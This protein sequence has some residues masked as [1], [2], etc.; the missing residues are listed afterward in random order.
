MKQIIAL[1]LML[2]ALL[3]SVFAADVNVEI[4]GKAIEGARLIN[5]VTY[6][7]LRDFSESMVESEILW[8]G[9]NMTAT[10]KSDG[11]LLLVGIGKAYVEGNG[12]PLYSGN[13]NL[14]LDGKTYAPIRAVA[15]AMGGEV[16]WNASSRTAS[17]EKANEPISTT[18]SGIVVLQH[19]A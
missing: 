18:D 7:P 3:P 14:I 16:S 13:K 2:S 4:D 9:A 15:L 17:V 5:S 10:V 12:R 19:P 11:L 1:F 8:D 6:V